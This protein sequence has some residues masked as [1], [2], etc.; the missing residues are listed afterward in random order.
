MTDIVNFTP[1]IDRNLKLS[2]LPE[3]QVKLPSKARRSTCVAMISATSSPKSAAYVALGFESQFY[4]HG[5][6]AGTAYMHTLQLMT[7]DDLDS[8]I[9]SENLKSK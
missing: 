1:S 9:S 7:V 2:Y 4:I 8:N 3:N 5:F 6:S